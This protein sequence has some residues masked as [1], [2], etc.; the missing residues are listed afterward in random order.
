MARV[1]TVTD[2]QEPPELP[3]GL[4]GVLIKGG[5][6]IDF[7]NPFRTKFTDENYKESLP[8]KYVNIF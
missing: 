4:F 3:N 7:M 1:A 8:C 2:C 6:G 5:I